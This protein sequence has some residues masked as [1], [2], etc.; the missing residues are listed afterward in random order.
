M[1][2]A[3]SGATEQQIRPSWMLELFI[4]PEKIY[5]GLVIEVQMLLESVW[6]HAGSQSLSVDSVCFANW[7]LILFSSVPKKS[8]F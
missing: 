1:H 5:G 7:F 6:M 4:P 2:A 8:Y 3:I